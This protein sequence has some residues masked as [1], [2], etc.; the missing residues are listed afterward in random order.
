[1]IHGLAWRFAQA[2]PAL[3]AGAAA[4]A[5]I[6]AVAAIVAWRGRS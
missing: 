2:E 1:M 6:I 3:I 4:I 5:F